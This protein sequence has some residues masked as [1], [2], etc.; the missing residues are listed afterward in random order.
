[1]LLHRIGFK[2]D[3]LSRSPDPAIYNF[4]T[5]KPIHSLPSLLLTLAV[6]LLA[7]TADRAL[8][9]TLRVEKAI[10]IPAPTAFSTNQTGRLFL[11]DTQ[12]VVRAYD[13]TGRVTHFFSPPRVA[14]VAALEAGQHLRV[15]CFYRDLQE[16]LVLD[17]FL[18][19]L[20]GYEKPVKIAPDETGFA[21][22]ATLAAD[23]QLWLFDDTDFSLKK[24]NPVT[25]R[26]SLHVPLEL[27]LAGQDPLFVSLREYQN[28]VFLHDARSGVLVFD[29]A[30]NFRSKIAAEAS[31]AVG[32]YGDELYFVRDG[33]LHFLHLYNGTTRRLALP[34]GIQSLNVVVGPGTIYLLTRNQLLVC[35]QP[36]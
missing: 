13:T 34:A 31:G 12:G 14:E 8:A 29:N 17:R 36:L 5:P 26:V 18:A 24:Y 30:G 20:P 33:A 11:G 7:V 9:Q 19:P 15:F 6:T 10:P 2:P 21:R 35:P 16:Y 27:V 25:R 1:M 23:G 32:F 28:L 22:L 3:P 4:L